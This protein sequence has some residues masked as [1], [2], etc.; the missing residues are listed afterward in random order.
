[1]TARP[2]PEFTA[3][4][5]VEEPRVDERAFRQGWIVRTRLDQ[6]LADDRITRAE[7]QAASEYRATW[8]IARELVGVEPGMIRVAGSSSADAAMIARVDAVTKLRIIEAAIGGLYARL[9]LAC[10]V[11]DLAW[12]R[13]ARFIGKHPETVRDRTVLAIRALASAW[14]TLHGRQDV[15]PPSRRRQDVVAL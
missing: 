6:L 2:T 1:M 13:T 11:H 10:L 3:H 4:H 14:G 7:W 12:A 9:L 8:A 15:C 5:D